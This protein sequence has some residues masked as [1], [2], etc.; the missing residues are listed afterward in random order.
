MKTI[1]RKSPIAK[2]L[3]TVKI[4]GL[5]YT[6]SDDEKVVYYGSMWN[7]IITDDDGFKYFLFRDSKRYLD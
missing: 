2:E 3:K 1:Q 4:G 6:I 5:P 7:E